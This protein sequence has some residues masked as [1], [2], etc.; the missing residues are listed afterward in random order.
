MDARANRPVG[1]QTSRGDGR[2]GPNAIIRLAEALRQLQGEAVCAEVFAQAG[3]SA[4]LA[5]PPER[6]VH[7][8]EVI[9]LHYAARGQLDRLAYREAAWLSGMLTGDYVLANR[10]PRP[11]QWL[12]RALPYRASAKMLASAIKQHAWTFVGSGT[13][14]FAP[15]P[16]GL[17]LE[18]GESPLARGVNDEEPVCDYYAA[19]FERMFSRLAHARVRV[20]EVECVANGADRCRFEVARRSSH[21]G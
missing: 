1:G 7:E 10:I 12:L 9:R 18:I 21:L 15:R 8:Q 5:E 17:I 11:V 6:M 16:G 14:A 19:S 4:Y 20:T 2:I 13:F 3:L